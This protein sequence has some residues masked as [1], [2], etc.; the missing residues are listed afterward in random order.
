MNTQ[1]IHIAFIADRGFGWMAEGFVHACERRDH[2]LELSR[3][4]HYM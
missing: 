3:K 1:F 2:R 4:K